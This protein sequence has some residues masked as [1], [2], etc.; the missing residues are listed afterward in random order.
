ML[1]LPA[2]FWTNAP[3]T[4]NFLVNE[5][6][7][8]TC[9]YMRLSEVLL[10]CI[11]FCLDSPFKIVSWTWSIYVNFDIVIMFIVLLV[12]KCVVAC[13]ALTVWIWVTVVLKLNSVYTLKNSL[14][15]G[16]FHALHDRKDFSIQRFLFPVSPKDLQHRSPPLLLRN[17][18]C[19]HHRW[20]PLL[21][22]VSRRVAWLISGI[23]NKISIF[24]RLG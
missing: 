2:V 18:P 6:C 8:S 20:V 10:V 24:K 19:L 21:L 4:C 5:D 22:P 17:L 11:I 3:C 14:Y 23:F 9:H 1:I 15:C 7:P 16:S 12:R 13:A